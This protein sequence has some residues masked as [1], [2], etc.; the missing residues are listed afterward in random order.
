MERA[1]APLNFFDLTRWRRT[2]P[3]GVLGARKAFGERI[4]ARRLQLGLTAVLVARQAATS[5]G[6][7]Y[8]IER[9]RQAA[10]PDLEEKLRRLL[11]LD[12][13]T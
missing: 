4:R 6:T 3:V 13:A 5:R 11:A 7:I 10:S 1:D 8:R 12:N 2:A 9:G